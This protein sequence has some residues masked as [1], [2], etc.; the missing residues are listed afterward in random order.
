M[1]NKI[2]ILNLNYK[3]LTISTCRIELGNQQIGGIIRSLQTWGHTAVFRHSD[4]EP[5]VRPYLCVRFYTARD[6]P[7]VN[8]AQPCPSTTYVASSGSLIYT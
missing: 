4:P 7:W 1:I 8:V 2:L 6:F 3:I 5:G